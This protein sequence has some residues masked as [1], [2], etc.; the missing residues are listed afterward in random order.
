MKLSILFVALFS[1]SA[2]AHFK[3][4]TYKGVTLEGADCEIKF[5]SVSFT[6]AFKNPLSERVTVSALNKIFILQHNAKVDETSVL[7]NEG[8][9]EVTIP[10]QGGAEFFK[11]AMIESNTKE[12]PDS[13]VHM[14]HDWKKNQLT[15]FSC[16]NLVFQDE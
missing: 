6:T 11:V 13:F 16:E 8:T 9:L 1:M 5:E 3:I 10:F 14:T 4:G 12:G 2:H 15:K 7:Y